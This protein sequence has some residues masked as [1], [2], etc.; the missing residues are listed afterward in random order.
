MP[1]ASKTH[2]AQLKVGIVAIV[3]LAILAVLIVTMSG[4]NPLFRKTETVYMYLDDSF[5]MSEGATPVRLNGILIGKVKKIG[6]SGDTK[7]NRSVRI[8]LALNQESLMDIPVDSTAKLAQQNL[9]GAR[10]VNISR[11]KA[12][13]RIQ[14]GGEIS[15]Q[16]TKE[17]EDLFEQGSSTLGAL[18]S[19]LTRVERIVVEIEDGKGTI[20]K[21]I[22]DET[23]YNKLTD[24]V[25][26]AKK[27]IEA[28]N[29]PNSS[30]GKII[31]DDGLY[32]EAEGTIKD[33]RG[34][35]AKVDQMVTAIN[36]GQ[37]TAGKMLHDTQLYDEATAAI[38]DLRET[39]R[40]VNQGDG[41][42]NKLLTTDTLHVRFE[43]TMSRLD[44][45]LDKINTGD[46]TV[47]QLL[48]NPALYESLDGTAREFQ[49]F[50]K[51]FRANPK[52]FL[53]IQLKLF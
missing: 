9:L 42:V 35:M 7:P 48:N 6:L 11:G 22:R 33:L 40:L 15:T 13:Q 43:E 25:D 51:D 24:T 28:I 29:N 53:T 12:A 41:T 34:T 50:M 14:P 52:K 47:G 38:G 31:N 27:L 5:A 46:G 1:S 19:I 10:Y 8:E 4:A 17:I 32:N 36:D 26:E 2:W 23:L 30:L 44:A 18:Q 3:A 49:G 39:L 16:D 21:F 37:G 20:G 45:V